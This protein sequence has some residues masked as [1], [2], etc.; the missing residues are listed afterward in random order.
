MAACYRTRNLKGH[1]ESLYIDS[2][3][4]V[5]ISCIT[6]RLYVV[7]IGNTAGRKGGCLR[8]PAYRA[9][10][11]ACRGSISTVI[12]IYIGC[13]VAELL[14]LTS[15]L[16]G[17]YVE[18]LKGK[19]EGSLR[20]VSINTITGTLTAINLRC[21]R[22]GLN[23]VWEDTVTYTGRLEGV[24]LCI[25]TANL[26]FMSSLTGVFGVVSVDILHLYLQC[27][28]RHGMRLYKLPYDQVGRRL[29]WQW[30]WRLGDF[31]VGS[32]AG[33]LSDVCIH[34][35]TGRQGCVY[36]VSIRGNP[37]SSIASA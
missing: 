22:W 8:I 18:N 3:T 33:S 27:Y 5:N 28:W 23:S 17:T 35:V 36:T 14:R 20:G 6:G 7:H 16:G 10:W 21:P 13:I 2:M 30:H 26:H 9:A 24:S 37:R 1:G 32:A 12:R 15:R 25:P 19:L 29:F 4:Y 31:S 34:I 11:G